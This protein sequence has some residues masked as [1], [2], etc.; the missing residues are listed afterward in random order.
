MKSI[1][2]KILIIFL[3][4]T[5]FSFIGSQLNMKKN[6]SQ[7]I[8]KF[9]LYTDTLVSG[10]SVDEIVAI[11]NGFKKLLEIDPINK[12]LE[13]RNYTCGFELDK[14]PMIG[15]QRAKVIYDI[16]EKKCKVPRKKIH[17]IDIES[18]DLVMLASKTICESMYKIKSVGII[19]EIH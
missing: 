5:S 15:F 13:L 18:R 8:I 16:L 1:L 17:Y 4:L 9:K 10:N 14:N 12:R 2:N 19:I 6:E 11:G 3:I 7:N